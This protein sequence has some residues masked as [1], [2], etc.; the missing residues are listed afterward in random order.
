[1][2]HQIDLDEQAIGRSDFLERL[3]DKFSRSAGSHDAVN[4]QELSR[5]EIGTWDVMAIQ[6]G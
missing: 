4:A 3:G 2:G 6:L 5:K 1:M